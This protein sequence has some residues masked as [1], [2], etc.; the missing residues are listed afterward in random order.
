MK[1]FDEYFSVMEWVT[2]GK[3]ASF[4]TENVIIETL[5]QNIISFQGRN[6]SSRTA[7]LTQFGRRTFVKL[8][9]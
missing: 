1:V 3:A 4:S 2:Y 9:R 6:Q 7:E 8:H 5:W